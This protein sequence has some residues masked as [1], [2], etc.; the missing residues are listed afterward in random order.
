VCSSDLF[1]SV[2]EG[3]SEHILSRIYDAPII[4]IAINVLI[5][6]IIFFTIGRQTKASLHPHLKTAKNKELFHLSTA[7]TLLNYLPGKPGIIAKGTYLKRRHG[8]NYKDY[9]VSA[10]ITTF[11]TVALSFLIFL[12]L[13]P[14]LKQ[15]QTSNYLTQNPSLL[16]TTLTV[17]LLSMGFILRGR[18]RRLYIFKLEGLIV[19]Y[20]LLPSVVAAQILNT[21]RLHI[22]FYAFDPEITITKS[23]IIQSLASLS[24]LL[25]IA[26]GNLGVKEGTIIFASKFL[27]TA[28]EI[29]LLAAF[30]DRL[31]AIIATFGLGP[32]SLI[33]L[34]KSN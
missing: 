3:T 31:S 4:V 8:I 33:Y 9:I 5:S 7:N 34:T 26:P 12:F 27:G 15:T 13:L 25:S 10:T 28:P 11:L 24:F 22:S 32:L 30:L 16:L 17:T 19:I 21:L 29:A 18:L 20:K 14:T 6:S 1:K 2:S 23:A